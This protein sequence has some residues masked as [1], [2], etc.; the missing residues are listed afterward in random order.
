MRDSMFDRGI[1]KI[2]LQQVLGVCRQI[3][4][5]RYDKV[6]GSWGSVPAELT[7]AKPCAIGGSGIAGHDGAQAQRQPIRVKKAPWRA[8]SFP[9]LTYLVRSFLKGDD[10]AAAAVDCIISDRA[11]WP[12]KDPTRVLPGGRR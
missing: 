12:A 11:S 2:G 9:A 6:C 7:P 1:G 5:V 10:P 3:F 4:P 8:P